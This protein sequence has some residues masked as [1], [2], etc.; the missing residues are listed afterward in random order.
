[1]ITIPTN[2]NSRIRIPAK[3]EKAKPKN[4][5]IEEP[6]LIGVSIEEAANMIGVSKATFV[7]LIKEDKVRTVRFGNLTIA[8]LLYS[9]TS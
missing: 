6:P 9:G 8:A 1:M 5:Q 2:T 3:A 7:S 4:K